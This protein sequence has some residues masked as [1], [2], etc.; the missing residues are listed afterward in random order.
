MTSNQSQPRYNIERLREE[1]NSLNKLWKL[2]REKLTKLSEAHI[3]EANQNVKFQL[4]KEIEYEE[5]ENRLLEE[6]LSE[7]EPTLEQAGLGHSQNDE[8]QQELSNRQIPEINQEIKEAEAQLRRVRK[9]LRISYPRLSL[10]ALKSKLS[11]RKN[12]LIIFV[13]VFTLCGVVFLFFIIIG[14]YN[15]PDVCKSPAADVISIDFSPDG[16]HLATASLDNKVRILKVTETKTPTDQNDSVDCKLHTD[17]VENKDNKTIGDG[18]VAVKFSPNGKYLATAG[19]NSA[20]LWKVNENDGKITRIDKAIKHSTDTKK[21]ERYDNPI[22][23][24][25]FS[26][27]S[28]YLATASSNGTIKV[29]DVETSTISNLLPPK[30]KPQASQAYIVSVSFSSDGN[31]IAATDVKGIAYLWDLKAPNGNPITA[32]SLNFVN[33][34]ITDVAFSLKDSNDRYLATASTDGTIQVWNIP[35]LQNFIFDVK[36]NTY[37]RDVSFSPS[38]KFIAAIGLDKKVFLWDWNS[39]TAIPWDIMY[40]TNVVD[41]AFSSDDN[42]LA[43]ADTNGRVRIWDTTGKKLAH[44]WTAKV[45]DLVTVAFSTTNEEYFVAMAGADGQ[46]EMRKFKPG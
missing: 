41:V 42:Y 32:L 17:D 7:I 46:I 16:T 9:R 43:I 10:E 28:K 4:E 36:V 20:R 27:D 23:A 29:R 1:H 2:R 40:N 25:D 11:S 26:H 31:Y 14:K 34:E 21:D 38:G 15:N 24:I 18:L 5:N 30:D 33:N 22:V 8:N 19:F 39:N 35:N 37:V 3:R 45:K 13:T 12:R 44:E 6:R